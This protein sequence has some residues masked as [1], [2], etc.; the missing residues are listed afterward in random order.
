MPHGCCTMQHRGMDDVTAELLIEDTKS[1]AK[2]QLACRYLTLAH[3]LDRLYLWSAYL[4]AFCLFGIFATTMLQVATRLVGVNLR[5]LTDYAGYF[6][7]ASAFFAFAHTF[8][9][10]SHIR[11]ELFLSLIGPFRKWG[12]RLSFFCASAVGIWL[13]WFAWS[14]VY[15]S[16]KLDD[17]SQGMDATP[18]WLPQMSMAL[19]LTLLALAIV[20]HTIRLFLL[21]DHQLPAAPD[22]L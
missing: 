22:A 7:A 6:M 19:G 18:L 8:N 2:S 1:Q 11:I 12:E 4:A 10:G 14:M 16:R 17:V 20:D 21:G 5:G 9:H 13:A 15:W 3:H